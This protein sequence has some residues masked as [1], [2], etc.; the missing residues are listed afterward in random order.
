MSQAESTRQPSLPSLTDSLVAVGVLIALVAASFLLF[1]EDATYGPN[2]VALT[3]AATL[4]AGL[5]WKSGHA[6]DDIR[7]A[8]VD[9]IASALPAIFILF[10]VG[11]PDRHLGDERHAGRDGVLCARRV[12]PKLLLSLRLHRLRA[13]GDQHRQ[14]VD[15]GRHHRPRAD[16]GGRR[17]GPLARRHGRSGDLGR[18]FRRQRCRHCPTP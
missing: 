14:L 13:G 6:W 7:N 17:D 16:G 12:E 11:G 5:A 10:A 2:Q 9:G 3:L 15:G 18:L 4:A 8:V 1:G